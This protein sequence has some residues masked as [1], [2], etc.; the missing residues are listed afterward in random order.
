MK[1]EK[2]H[3]AVFNIL[4]KL[5]RAFF[6]FCI[7]TFCDWFKISHN[8]LH[9][10]EVKLTPLVSRMTGFPALRT[11]FMYRRNLTDSL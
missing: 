6:G 9:Q 11:N 1:I 4:A 10:L 2:I 3:K 5:N 8:F 7:S